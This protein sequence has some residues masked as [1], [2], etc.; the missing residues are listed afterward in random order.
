MQANR[1]GYISKSLN[2][3]WNADFRVV[4]CKS[5]PSKTCHA[6]KFVRDFIVYY[7]HQFYLTYQ[8]IFSSGRIGHYCWICHHFAWLYGVYTGINPGNVKLVHILRAILFEIFSWTPNFSSQVICPPS[9]PWQGCRDSNQTT[10]KSTLI[11]IF[12]IG[13]H[14][15]VTCRKVIIP[16]YCVQ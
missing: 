1:L 5:C 12:R 10:R 13:C 4:F 14:S 8:N 6:A 2:S 11:S 3:K 15:H 7:Y 16:V 9:L